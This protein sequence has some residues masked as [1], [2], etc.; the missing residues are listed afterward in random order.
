MKKFLSSLVFFALTAF[1]F[2]A[3]IP[4]ATAQE[5]TAQVADVS[6]SPVKDWIVNN[7]YFVLPIIYDLLVRLFPTGQ[8]YSIIS[9]VYNLVMRLIPDN[10]SGG[11]THRP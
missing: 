1:C 9:F 4:A 11:G 8:S 7:W 3:C 6:T 5:L 2:V 10:K